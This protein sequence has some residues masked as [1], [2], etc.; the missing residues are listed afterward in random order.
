VGSLVSRTLLILIP[1]HRFEIETSGKD[2]KTVKRFS[3]LA[4]TM[5]SDAEATLT[6]LKILTSFVDRL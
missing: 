6:K 5:R 2:S 3:G 4:L 1:A